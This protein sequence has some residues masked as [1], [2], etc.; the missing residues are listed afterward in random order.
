[1]LEFKNRIKYSLKWSIFHLLFS[2]LIIL[3][4]TFFLINFWFPGYLFKI[5]GAFNL[6][7]VVIVVDVVCG[8]ILT[9]LFIHPKK[10]PNA[11][12]LD[13]ILIFILQLCALV[14]G[15]YHFSLARPIAIVFE[16]DRFHVVSY[17]DLYLSDEKNMPEWVSFFGLSG[18]R[19]L[20]TRGAIGL[21]EKMSSIHASLQGVEPGQRPD[22]WQSYDLSI[23]EIKRR[24]KKLDIL[25]KMHPE[26]EDDILYVAR[27]II[28]DKK[29]NDIGIQDLLWLPIVSRHSMDWVAFISSRNAEIIGYMNIDGFND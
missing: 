6:F 4:L 25:L 1:M 20:S 5:S 22:W 10:S 15:V 23:E 19:M 7:I 8:P 29:E 26:N 2:F 21:E 18:P 3:I 11:R 24:A 12:L 9:L 13:I 14:Y 27:K 28:A 16:K 17:A